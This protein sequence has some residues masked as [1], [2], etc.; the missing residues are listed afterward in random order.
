MREEL[1][2]IY[3][4]QYTGITSFLHRLTSGSLW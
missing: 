1:L 4:H 2:A 3:L